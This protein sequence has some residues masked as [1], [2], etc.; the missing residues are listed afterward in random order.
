MADCSVQTN[1]CNTPHGVAPARA[2][3]VDVACDVV[4]AAVIVSGRH[5]AL[6]RRIQGIF[7]IPA[8]AHVPWALG[9]G[10]AVRRS[11]ICASGVAVAVAAFPDM[12]REF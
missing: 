3:P 5:F 8:S 1:T 10:V 6:D 12:L 4:S 7:S 9:I 2:S 11:L